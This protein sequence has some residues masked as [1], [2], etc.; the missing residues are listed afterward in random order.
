MIIALERVAIV[1]AALALAIGV[2]A[3]LSGGLFT[4]SDKAAVNSTVDGPGTAVRDLGHAALPDHHPRIV[5]DSDPPAS[6][7][8][9]AEPVRRDEARLDDDQLLQALQV[10]DVV[11]MYGTP[12]PPVRLHALARALAPR[13]SPRWPPPARRSSWS[14]ARASAGSSGSPGRT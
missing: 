4:G 9:A 7:P 14:A 13:F 12:R 8:H 1:V 10:G 5:Y 11:L 2:I 3:L 6:G